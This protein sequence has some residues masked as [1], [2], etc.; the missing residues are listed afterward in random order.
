MNRQ[1]DDQ[2]S[3]LFRAEVSDAAPV[4]HDL[5]EPQRRKPPPVPRPREPDPIEGHNQRLSESEVETHDYLVF[6]RPGIQKRLMLEL[7]RG[8]FEPRIDLDLHGLRVVEAERAVREFLTHC[9]QERIR[10]ARII[11]GKGLGSED[12]QP[13]LKQK[14]NYWL[15]LRE[16]VLAFCSAPRHQGGTGATHLLLRNPDKSRRPRTTT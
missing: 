12:R 8:Q 13:V 10:C 5:I 1:P 15:R 2:D 14:V 11:H 3:A 4:H 16:D 7:Q 6:S 9:H